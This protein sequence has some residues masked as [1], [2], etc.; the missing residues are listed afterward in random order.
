MFFKNRF[1]KP[2]W[3]VLLCLCQYLVDSGETLA[4][5]LFRHYAAIQAAAQEITKGLKL[6]RQQLE[7]LELAIEK[8]EINAEDIRPFFK[9]FSQRGCEGDGNG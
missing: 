6:S 9:G 8:Q 3:N 7:I 1:I 4:Q 5:Q 2:G